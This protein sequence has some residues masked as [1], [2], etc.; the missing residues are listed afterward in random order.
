MTAETCAR[1]Y[2]TQTIGSHG[3]GSV[4]VTDKGKTFISTFFKE[5]WILEIKQ[6]HSTPVHPQVKGVVERYYRILNHAL[7]H[8]VNASG[9]NWDDLLTLCV[10]VYRAT[11]HR[12]TG[13]SPFYWL[14]GRETI[15]PTIQSVTAK[16]SP[17]VRGTNYAGPL[18][19]LN[20]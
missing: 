9:T 4:F 2:A 20:V 16:L 14:H 8:Y 6:L 10:M 12:T 18:E 19:N 15:L 13:F 3:T 7:N 11:L 5:S 1:A 17:E